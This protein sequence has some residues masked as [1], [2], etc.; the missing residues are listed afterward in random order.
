MFSSHVVSNIE[1]FGLVRASAYMLDDNELVVQ[2]LYYST[3]AVD[4]ALI[5]LR[6][7]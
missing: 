6:V 4:S 5:V 3:A 1:H 2:I 7:C